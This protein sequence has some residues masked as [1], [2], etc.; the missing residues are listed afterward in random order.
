MVGGLCVRLLSDTRIDTFLQMLLDWPL[1]ML[2]IY[3]TRMGRL[4]QYWFA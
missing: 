2:A 1:H 3:P 4:R